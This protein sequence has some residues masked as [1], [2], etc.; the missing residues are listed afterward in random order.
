MPSEMRRA[1][2]ALVTSR[3]EVFEAADPIEGA[4]QRLE[5]ALAA[6]GPPSALAMSGAW[7]AIDGR[8]VYEVTFAPAPRI[9]RFLHGLSLA[10]V[11]LVAASAWMLHSA[12]EGAALKFLVPLF[13]VLAIIAMPLVVTGIASHREAEESRLTRTIRAALQGTSARL[14]PQQRWPD[15]N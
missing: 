11:L 1:A 4:R 3:V 10:L 6:G 13:T 9:R 12:A 2:K 8:A 14:P 15:E 5:Q 7:K